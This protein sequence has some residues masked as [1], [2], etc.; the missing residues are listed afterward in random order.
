MLNKAYANDN[1]GEGT[2]TMIGDVAQR[3]R[4]ADTR[5]NTATFLKYLRMDNIHTV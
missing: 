4:H 1:D 2:A 5:K 3:Q